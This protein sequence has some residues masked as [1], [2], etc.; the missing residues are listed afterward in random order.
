MD[1]QTT[2]ENATEKKKFG[3]DGSFGIQ[4]LENIFNSLSV[5]RKLQDDDLELLLE[6]FSKFRKSEKPIFSQFEDLMCRYPTLNEM[7]VDKLNNQDLAELKQASQEISTVLNN[8]K[9]IW[10]RLIQ[11][12]VGNINELRNWT[13]KLVVEKTPTPIVKDLAVAVREFFKS[14]PDKIIKQHIGCQFSPLHIA[15]SQ[16]DFQLC[17]HIMR[18]LTKTN[19]KNPRGLWYGS[20]LHV[21][22]EKGH[23]EIFKFLLEKS[24][25]VNPLCENR[26][27]PFHLAA[28]NGH[29]DVCR[30]IMMKLRNTKTA[31]ENKNP[32]GKHGM[33]PLHFATMNGHFYICKLIIANAWNKNPENFCKDT[34]LHLAAENGHLNIVKLLI[35]NAKEKMPLNARGLTPLHVAA[36]NNHGEICLFLLE[37][38][39]GNF[40]FLQSVKIGKE[41][42]FCKIVLNSIIEKEEIES[43]EDSPEMIKRTVYTLNP[44]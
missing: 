19:N 9:A 40:D 7:I 22:A 35:G 17:K 44:F 39:L 34:P 16:C 23:F 10:I 4:G 28:K 25:D 33:T 31:L 8:S 13:W 29:L 6:N 5:K 2:I 41:S 43:F 20:A 15:T 1:W 42:D 30:L 26:W 32:A 36:E 18:R 37:S 27:T 3:T 14:Y 12:H 38:I 21:A 11:S 24:A